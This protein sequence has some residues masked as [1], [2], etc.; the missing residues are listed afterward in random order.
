LGR[1]RS[2][3]IVVAL[4][5]CKAE[6]PPSPADIADRGWHAHELVIAAGERARTCADAGSAMQKVFAENR[7]AFVDAIALDQDRERL[8]IATEWL[9]AHGQRYADLET[10]MEALSERCGDDAA[11]Q[12]VFRQMEAP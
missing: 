12:A 1:V 5:G 10:R 9:E 4:A 2:F 3:L 8:R 6:R 7:P 11:V